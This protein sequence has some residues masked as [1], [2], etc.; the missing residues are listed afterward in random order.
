[1][2]P[3][4]VRSPGAPVAIVGV[5]C[6]FPG[7]EGLEGFREL[8]QSG[9][10]AVA[11]GEPGSGRGRIGDLFRDIRPLPDPRRYGAFV[12]D[13]YRFD[14]AFFGISDNEA[15]LMDPQHRLLLE[16]SWHA[17][18][19]AAI[20]PGDLAGSRTGVFAGVGDSGYRERFPA[21]E[22]ATMYAAIG[23][24]LNAAIGRIAYALGLEGP[25]LAV[26]TASSSSLVAVHQ[27]I[28]ALERGEADLALAGGVNLIL[29]PTRT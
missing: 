16:V 17:L 21:D 11:E 12:E 15:R 13:P 26:D 20:S 3:D 22:A 23:N 6:R 28:L 25:A 19:N 9:G 27:A 4:N 5:A 7:G 2:V 1:M 29:S 8:L 18:E 10:D 14:A 24:S